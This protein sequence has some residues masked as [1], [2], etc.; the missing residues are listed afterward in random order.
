MPDA[1]LSTLFNGHRIDVTETGHVDELRHLAPRMAEVLDDAVTFAA[2]L[3]WTI[4]IT[5][6]YR[7]PRE[8]ELLGGSRIHCQAP[9]RAVDIRTRDV[10]DRLVA[11]LDRHL[12]D[13]WVYCPDRPKLTVSYGA[14]HGSGPHLHLQVSPTTRRRG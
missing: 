14:K 1:L 5:S 9:H 10:D 6:V 11:D 3:G 13:G 12:D 7:T 2:R 8:D 4:T